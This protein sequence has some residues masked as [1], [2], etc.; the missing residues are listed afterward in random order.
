MKIE[1]DT[2]RMLSDDEKQEDFFGNLIEKGL[3]KFEPHIC[4][5][6]VHLMDIHEAKK[7]V[8][9]K[10]CILEARLHGMQPVTISCQAK[11]VKIAVLGA[12]EKLK[13]SLEKQI[14]QLQNH[15]NQNQSATVISN[16]SNF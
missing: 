12:I 14:A 1:F 8:L 9:N 11:L 10:S 2:D 7:G 15:K 16:L 13:S 4:R 6:E 3:N 5:I